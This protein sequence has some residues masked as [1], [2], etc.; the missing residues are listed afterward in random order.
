MFLGLQTFCQN[1][2]RVLKCFVR[3]DTVYAL[4]CFVNSMHDSQ[5]MLCCFALFL[6]RSEETSGWCRWN[7]IGP[8]LHQSPVVH[9]VF[10]FALIFI[11]PCSTQFN[12]QLAV[13]Q[14]RPRPHTT[15]LLFWGQVFHLSFCSFHFP[16]PC[17]ALLLAIFP[18][19]SFRRFLDGWLPTLPEMATRQPIYDFKNFKHLDSGASSEFWLAHVFTW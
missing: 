3:L 17:F 8:S 9:T 11:S 16:S 14:L 13:F 7:R 4:G 6:H 15:A 10:S 1:C 2:C 19:I 18:L 5:N 12:K